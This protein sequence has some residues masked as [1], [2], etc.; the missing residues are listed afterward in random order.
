MLYN[1]VTEQVSQRMVLHKLLK[2]TSIH[3][4]SVILNAPCE[5]QFFTGNM[6]ERRR[7]GEPQIDACR[8]KDSG[9]MDGGM[10]GTGGKNS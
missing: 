10:Q 1:I 9:W 4:W 5:V 2:K 3:I 7:V 8:V 6:R